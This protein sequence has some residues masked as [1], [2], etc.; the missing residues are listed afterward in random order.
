MENVEGEKSR[1]GEMGIGRCVKLRI[2][3]EVF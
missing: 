3:G 2:R 1:K